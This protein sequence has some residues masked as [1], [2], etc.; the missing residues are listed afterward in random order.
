MCAQQENIGEPVYFVSH[1]GKVQGKSGYKGDFEQLRGLQGH[2]A[3]VEPRPVPRD[4]DAHA[5]EYQHGQYYCQRG[6]YHP[7]LDYLVVV[8]GGKYKGCDPAGYDCGCLSL[9]ER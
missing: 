2:K 3:E 6:I 9:V 5:R 7:Q 1:L 8:H 4:L